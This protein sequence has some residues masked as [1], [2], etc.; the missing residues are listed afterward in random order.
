MVENATAEGEVREEEITSEMI[1]AGK[2][3][4]SGY[5]EDYES[6]DDAVKRI[7]LTMVEAKVLAIRNVDGDLH[8]G[9][10]DGVIC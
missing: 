1:K 7:Y 6:A 2:I 3:A 5:N 10:S 4:L 8:A 9:V